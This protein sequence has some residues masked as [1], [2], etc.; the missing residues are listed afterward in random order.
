MN[1]AAGR[2]FFLRAIARQRTHF[3]E[4]G[5]MIADLTAAFRLKIDRQGALPGITSD[6]LSTY[7]KQ[8]IDHYREVLKRD[9]A[10][11]KSGA[12]LKELEDAR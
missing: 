12:A 1:P 3:S 4:P 11:L 10:D 2:A 8:L 5:P 6:V 9:P 7:R